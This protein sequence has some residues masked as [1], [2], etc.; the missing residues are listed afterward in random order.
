MA[1]TEICW[2]EFKR[3]RCEAFKVLDGALTREATPGEGN[4]SHCVGRSVAVG[5]V[6]AECEMRSVVGRTAKAAGIRLIAGGLQ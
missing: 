2:T 6:V 1:N 3:G 4:R 5:S